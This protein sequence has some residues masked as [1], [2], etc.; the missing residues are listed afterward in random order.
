VQILIRIDSRSPRT[1]QAQIVE[2]FHDLI[3]GG[4]LRPGSEVPSSRELSEQLHVSRNTV[5]EAY[6]L[7][8][9]EGY[10][11]T[12]RAVGTFVAERVPDESFAVA[13]Q[14]PHPRTPSHPRVVNLPLPYTGR[15]PPGL[16]APDHRD[17]LYDFALS[18][19][20]PKSFPERIWRRLTLDCLGGSAIRMSEYMDPAGLPDLRQLITNFLGPARGMIVSPEQ[21]IIVAGCQQGLSLAAHLFIGTRTRVAME[22]PCYRGAAFLFESYGGKLLPVPVD[23]LGMDVAH[24]PEPP[25][26]LAYVTPSHQFP[27]GVTLSLDR[28]IALLEWAAKVGAYI[29]EVDYDADF[30]YEGSPLPS[31]QALDR[32]GCVIYMSSFSRSIG[33]GLRLGYIVVPRDLIGAATIIKALTDNGPP[34]LEQATLAAFI[35]EGS[36]ANHL[37]RIRHTYRGRRDA[38]TRALHRHFGEVAISGADCGEHVV[39][40]LPRHLPPAQDLQAIARTHGVGVYSLPHSPAY[41]YEQMEDCDRT[42]LLGYPSLTEEQIE[43]GVA[44]LAAAVGR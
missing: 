34:W 28:R 10:L 40:R 41:L 35:R 5:V 30:R 15:G 19:T 43:H 31:L 11:Y 20:D 21:V 6:D 33:P 25:V 44:R 24:M 29:L 3:R 23:H 39:W 38:L 2:G 36:L 17:L 16:H 42:L 9:E 14:Q 27:T 1:L 26:T 32:N 37:K 12:Q 22:A 4:R 8:I 7:L 13:A 18:R